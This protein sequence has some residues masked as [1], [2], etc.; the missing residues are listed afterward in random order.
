MPLNNPSEVN[1]QADVITAWS[2]TM[3]VNNTTVGLSKSYLNSNYTNSPVGY[4]VMCPN[5]LLGGAIYKRVTPGANGTWQTI[6]APP[7]L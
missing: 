1:S 3:T 7:A 4:E 6:S 5:I 2:Q